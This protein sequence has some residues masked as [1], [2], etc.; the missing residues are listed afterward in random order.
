MSWQMVIYCKNM[1]V[2][3][4]RIYFVVMWCGG[5]M[6]TGGCKYKMWVWGDKGRMDARQFF[7]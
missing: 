5:G 7:S 4:I 3:I 2:C 6:G 1:C